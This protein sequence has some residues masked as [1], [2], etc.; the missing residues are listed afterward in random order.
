MYQPM[1]L[2]HEQSVTALID[3]K[4]FP[5]HWHSEIEL[6][7][8]LSGELQAVVSG[9]SYPLTPGSLLVIGSAE[10][11]SF[12]EG[13]KGARLLL[14][15]M[16]FS[17]LGSEFSALA[18]LRFTEPL[19][20]P[21]QPDSPAAPLLPLLEDLLEWHGKPGP[22]AI[23]TCKSILFSLASEL[24]QLPHDIDLPKIRKKRL[25]TQLRCQAV[26]EYIRMHYRRSLPLEEVANAIGYEKSN[27]CKLFK[28]AT[29]TSFHKY[30]NAYRI[31]IAC[32]LLESGEG[33]MK[34]IGEQV[35][36]PE[37][38]SFSRIFR[39]VMGVTPTEYRER[40]TRYE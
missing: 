24:F 13:Q 19:L 38:K 10:E 36:I 18:A 17:F 26:F 22:Q 15:E 28:R 31:G 7:Y 2:G 40:M 32:R 14:V 12:P 16:G 23:W 4:A 9:V 39:Q 1:L 35:G 25:E 33:S 5:S 27:F 3:Q 37:P 11:H 20:S 34:S 8:C 21:C 30:L 29:Q 6:L